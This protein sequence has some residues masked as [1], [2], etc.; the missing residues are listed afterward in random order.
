M[1]L[2]YCIYLLLACVVFCFLCNPLS[3]YFLSDDFD[4]MYMAQTWSGVIHSYRPGSDF[5]L[6]TD[7][8]LYGY[9]AGGYHIT[10]YLLHF[11]TTFMLFFTT[12]QLLF[13]YY[14][15]EERDKYA[16]VASFI[17]LFYPFHS[18]CIFW[19]VGR[20]SL[21]ATLFALCSIYGWLRKKESTWWYV[22]SL[23]SLGLGLFSYESIWTLPAII[24]LLAMV[25]DKA[26]GMKMKLLYISGYWLIFFLYLIARWYLTTTVI[27]SPYGTQK[28][29][30][31]D[32]LFLLRNGASLVSRSLVPPM[33]SSAAFIISLGVMVLVLAF[34]VYTIRKRITTPILIMVTAYILCLLPVISLGIDTHDT[35][36]ERFLYM[37]SAFL[38]MVLS[39]IVFYLFQNKTAY[40]AGVL[41]AVQIF[42]LALS[43]RAFEGAGKVTKT[44]V[45]ALQTLQ[46]TDSVYCINLPE[47]YKG[48]F[49]FRNGIARAANLFAPEVKSVRIL[50]QIELFD[51]PGNYTFQ[52]YPIK[53]LPKEI[54][55][56]NPALS[57]PAGN[58]V[59]VWTN[60]VLNV[61][62]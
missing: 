53:D 22:L 10:N 59:F 19:L 25:Y 20:S 57:L 24:I 36:S 45:Q 13:P 4:S 27:G 52:L 16:M 38:S 9:Q 61:Y 60:H 12:R 6:H 31:F 3:L 62:K 51:Y 56:R 54:S 32:M 40:A 33:Q 21:L 49:I 34:A 15:K 46:H 44:T 28:I 30:T 2:K 26:T 43:Y 55:L 50:S 29:V 11:L 8:L 1:K 5:L 47:Q 37:P 48:G 58:A 35:E 14:N 42:F 23:I 39:A 17:F 18:E 41:L 7:H